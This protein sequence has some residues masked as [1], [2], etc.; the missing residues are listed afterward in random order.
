MAKYF[1]RQKKNKEYLSMSK[2]NSKVKAI[3]LVI[4]IILTIT[5][6]GILT[7]VYFNKTAH[8]LEKDVNTASEAVKAKNWD[9]A[10]TQLADFE[11]SWNKTKFGW[12][13]LLDHFEID[14]IDNT[15]TKSRKFVE[16]GDFSS[17]L[18]E[19]EALKKYILH[20]PQKENFSIENIL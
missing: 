5:I 18:A 20:I 2:L 17:A 3:I 16:A 10:N 8:D 6:S 11:R 13:I 4:S 19:L 9:Y 7:L 15:F 12:A 14:N 1:A